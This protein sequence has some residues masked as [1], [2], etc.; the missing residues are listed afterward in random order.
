MDH[1]NDPAV[2][3]FLEHVGVKGMRW[4]VRKDRSGSSGSN[5]TTK[6][7]D[8]ATK[9]SATTADGTKKVTFDKS[10]SR[11][12]GAVQKV[13]IED[14]DGT[15]TPGIYNKKTRVLRDR[16]KEAVDREQSQKL[17]DEFGT[18]AL[19]NIQLQSYVKRVE[20]ESRV[21]QLNPP[22]KSLAKKFI[23]SEKQTIVN[24]LIKNPADPGAALKS[25]NTVKIGMAIN[26]AMKNQGKNKKSAKK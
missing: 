22:K 9:V 11:P 13:T 24:N 23:D 6:T 17:L 3:E 21:N 8:P 12:K 25:A 4:G 19:S 16:A 26:N 18:D 10:K 7:K 5:G 2:D 1:V 15:K 14:E 20:L